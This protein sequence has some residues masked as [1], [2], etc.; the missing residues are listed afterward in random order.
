MK[1]F[2]LALSVIG[3]IVGASASISFIAMDF[4]WLTSESPAAYLCRYLVLSGGFLA[5]IR[6]KL[7]FWDGKDD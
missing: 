2:K 7:F 6:Y 1:I 5:G 4:T 3:G